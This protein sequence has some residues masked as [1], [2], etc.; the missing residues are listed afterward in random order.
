MYH[1][2]P[3]ILYIPATK[4]VTTIDQVAEEVVHVIENP[5]APLRNQTPVFAK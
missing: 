4:T 1:S 2:P 5:A 3:D